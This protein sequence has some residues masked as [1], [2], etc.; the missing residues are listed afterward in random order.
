MLLD[1]N[2]K[3]GITILLI[4]HEMHVIRSICDR[5]AVMDQGSII[6]SGDVLSVFLNP[7]H[8]RTR[9]FVS[10]VSDELDTDMLPR[11]LDEFDAAAINTNYALQA[12][13]NPLE[14][15]LVIEG[16]ESPYV[17]IVA[18]RPDNKDSDAIQKL[19]AVLQ[20]PEVEK[21]IN[22]TYNGAVVPAFQ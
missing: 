16:A 4:T 2:R 8:E 17:N 10:Q 5:V 15:A 18:A 6:E 9:E 7:Q 21:F 1:I 13:L 20:S 11:V 22:E 12:D 14:D 19:I 3:L